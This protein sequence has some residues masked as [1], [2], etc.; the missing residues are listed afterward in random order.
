MNKP[1]TPLSEN[2]LI[3]YVVNH[4]GWWRYQDQRTFQFAL[5]YSWS[6]WSPEWFYFSQ[7]KEHFKILPVF[8]NDCNTHQMSLYSVGQFA[9]SILLLEYL[10]FPFQ[11]CYATLNL[12]FN[13]ISTTKWK[14]VT[15]KVN[16]QYLTA[17]E[18][19]L[20]FFC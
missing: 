4:T 3:S 18:T 12:L 16:F 17:S 20:W 19:K 13:F 2:W 11:F 7:D 15:L 9:S 1:E 5:F 14:S 8:F 10:S 6:S